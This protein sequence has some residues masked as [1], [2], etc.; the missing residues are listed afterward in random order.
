[1]NVFVSDRLSNSVR[2]V[3]SYRLRSYAI[4]LLH[5]YVN[6]E[7]ES[8][9]RGISRKKE[10]ERERKKKKEKSRLLYLI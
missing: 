1:M 8:S 2:S 4:R 6:S 10:E 9:T 7:N 5:N 3:T